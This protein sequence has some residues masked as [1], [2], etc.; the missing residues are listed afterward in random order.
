MIYSDFIHNWKKWL[1]CHQKNLLL[2]AGLVFVG[3]LAF[4]AGMLRGALRQPAPLVLSIPAISEEKDN[5]GD[6]APAANAP[7][8]GVERTAAAVGG[9]AGSAKNCA[10]VGSRN[11]N[12]FH[13]P[14]CAVAKRI[15]PENIVCFVSEEDAE[16]RGY[17]A[18]CLK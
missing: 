12:K 11:S 5:R 3:V 6:P 8:K 9:A 4:E 16:K 18:G 10:F 13:L 17:V 2:L 15:K 1:I 14:T 7:L